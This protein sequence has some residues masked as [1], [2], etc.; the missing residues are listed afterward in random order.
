M[1]KLEN[2]WISWHFLSLCLCVPLT[3]IT[4][5]QTDR[6]DRAGQE[7]CFRACLSSL[8]WFEESRDPLSCKQKPDPVRTAWVSF[9]RRSADDTRSGPGF[10]NRALMPHKSPPLSL[11]LNNIA[12]LVPLQGALSLWFPRRGWAGGSGRLTAPSEIHLHKWQRTRVS[13]I[14]RP[15][16]TIPNIWTES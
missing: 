6:Q 4:D 15:R 10:G 8:L 13:S 14:Y 3:F 2:P 9:P 12:H 7:G 16:V 1:E 11:L 5:R